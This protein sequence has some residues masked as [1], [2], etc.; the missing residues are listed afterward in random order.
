MSRSKTKLQFC[1]LFCHEEKKLHL[2]CQE[3]KE[4]YI[5]D[6]YF[7]SWQNSKKHFY[8]YIISRNFIV[9]FS[10]TRIIV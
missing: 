5:F 7:N 3:A 10:S 8:F 4:N 6:T 2:F 9:R 1:H